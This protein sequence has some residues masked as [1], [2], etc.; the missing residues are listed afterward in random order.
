MFI[1]DLAASCLDGGAVLHDRAGAAVPRETIRSEYRAIKGFLFDHAGEG[2]IAAIRLEHGYRYVLCVCACMEVG[3]TYLPL[4]VGWPQARIDQI[5][6]LAG[7][8][9]LIDESSIERICRHENRRS[10]E[11]FG[12]EGSKP[13]YVICTSGSTGEPKGVVVARSSYEEFLRWLA[14]F[15]AASGGDERV[16][17]MADFTF[18]QSLCD[19]GSFLLK[20]CA[21]YFSRFG[22]DAFRLAR[23]IESHRISSLATVPRNIGLLLHET[24]RRKADLSSLR[25]LLIGGERF[26]VELHESLFR[27]LPAGAAAYNC[28]G[29]TETTIFSHIKRLTGIAERDM[30][31][32]HVSVG[33]PLPGVR[34]RLAASGGVELAAPGARA[35]LLL[36]G[37]Q[38][39]LGYAGDPEGTSRRVTEIGGVRFFRS[40]DIAFRDGDGQ[41]YITGRTDLT[42]KR[43]GYRIDLSDIDSYIRRIPFVAECATIAVP[44][45]RFEHLLIC[46]V[47]ARRPV[48]EKELRAEMAKV[49]VDFQIPDRVEF[50]DRLPVNEAGKISRKILEEDFRRKA[51]R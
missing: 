35:E 8:S 9:L 40:G 22:G 30:S 26:P 51:R 43:R 49:L 3:L 29:P 48:A 15:S 12:L 45:D 11:S 21:L 47:V 31:D 33:R 23:E 25:R 5:K 44:D 28:Y 1:R 24:V 18:D 19:V 14:A 39:M 36:G 38:V 2:D 13:L 46:S 50:V 4:N 17:L 32:G 41:Y 34:C 6:R 37:A 16:L 27:A 7:F 20:R 10:R 42:L